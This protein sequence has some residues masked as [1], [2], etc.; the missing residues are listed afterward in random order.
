MILLCKRVA[1]YIPPYPRVTLVTLS[2]DYPLVRTI[3][4]DSTLWIRS[5]HF[6]TLNRIVNKSV[7]RAAKAAKK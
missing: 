6:L 4:T 5:T 2:I 3:R 1:R 7:R